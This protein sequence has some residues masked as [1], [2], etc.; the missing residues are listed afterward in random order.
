MNN[1]NSKFKFILWDI[2]GTLINFEK[3]ERDSIFKCFSSHGINLSEDDF[4]K[5]KD[6]NHGYWKLIEQGKIDKKFALEKRFEDVLEYLGAEGVT[7]TELNLQYQNLL[8]ENCVLNDDAYNLCD[9]F[10]KT[11]KQYIVTNGTIIAQKKKLKT[12]KLGELMDGIFISDEIGFEKPHMGFFNHCFEAI[13]GFKKEEAIIIGDTLTSDIKGGNNA[14]I[15]CC[16]YNP[17]NIS[18]PEEYKVDY[19]IGNLQELKEI[20]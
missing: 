10:R 1:R 2:D 8:G 12:T 7:S 11:H 18:L 6:I 19:I 5:Y 14:G 16:W 9:E 17:K 20:L 3:S 15:K 4:N 13:P